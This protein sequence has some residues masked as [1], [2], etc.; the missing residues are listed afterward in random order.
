[1][2]KCTFRPPFCISTKSLCLVDFM[3]LSEKYYNDLHIFD[4]DQFKW[5]EIKRQP[6]VLWPCPR[7]GFQ[8][9]VYQDE[10][11]LYGGYSKE[12][13]TDKNG[14]EKGIV[15][16]DMWVLDPRTWEW[17]KV[18]KVGIAPGPRAG[19]SMCIHKKRA[20]L[21]GGVVDME[22]EGDSLMSLFMNELYGFQLDTRRWYPLELRKDKP[23]KEKLKEV[24]E[25]EVSNDTVS[26]S[27]GYQVGSKMSIMCEDDENVGG[28]G[29]EDMQSVIQ[30]LAHHTTK[31]LGLDTGNVLDVKV[32]GLEKNSSSEVVRPCGRINTCMVVGKD[33]LYLYG[34]MM[35]VKD[36]EI[37][38][39]D[40]YSLNLCKLDQWNCIK[41]ASESEWLEISDDEEEEEEE[42]E[43]DDDDD[44]F[45]DNSS[46]GGSD[47]DETVEDDEDLEFVD[48]A[49]SPIDLG[50]AISILKGEKKNIR[51]KEKRIR[52]EQIRISLGLADSQRTPKVNLLYKN[53]VIFYSS[54]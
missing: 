48:D 41:S 32:Q 8:L 46:D 42:E 37:T 10:I 49:E 22:V 52:I 14:L 31:S 3:T 24:K 19:F 51:R 34:G 35:E 50:N 33:I 16:S 39:D 44:D 6:G 25:N 15:H 9:F 38:L 45:K 12:V 20:V 54:I 23:I 1:M 28:C 30:E 40:L 26:S 21:F 11:F 27:K 36:R 2:P 53:V 4:L 18:K 13:S 29:D 5:Q 17:N 47:T 7:S 43:E